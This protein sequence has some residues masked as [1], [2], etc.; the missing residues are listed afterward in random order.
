MLYHMLFIL[1]WMLSEVLYEILS[2][3]L[4]YVLLKVLRITLKWGPYQIIL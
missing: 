1:Y 2:G 4:F 3:V